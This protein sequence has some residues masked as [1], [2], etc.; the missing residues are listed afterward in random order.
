[1]GFLLR[2]LFPRRFLWN[3][4]VSP[5]NGERWRLLAYAENGEGVWSYTDGNRTIHFFGEAPQ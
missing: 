4:G 2:L 5:Y 3:D 1:M